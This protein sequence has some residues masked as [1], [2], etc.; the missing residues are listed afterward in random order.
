MYWRD[1]ILRVATLFGVGWGRLTIYLQFNISETKS[2]SI[3]CGWHTIEVGDCVFLWQVD[4]GT[5]HRSAFDFVQEGCVA[6]WV[7]VRLWLGWTPNRCFI[8][9]GL[10]YACQTYSSGSLSVLDQLDTIPA[11]R[12]CICLGFLVPPPSMLYMCNHVRISAS[13]DDHSTAVDF[14]TSPIYI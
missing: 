9:I 1:Q 11:K 13:S 8:S 2:V 6:A 4:S 10:E 7:P 3:I 14:D 12:V 5:A